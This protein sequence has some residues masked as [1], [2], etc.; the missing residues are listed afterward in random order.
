[1][2]FSDVVC[3]FCGCLCDDLQVTVE[4]G[5]ITS[6]AKACVLGKDHIM[7]AQQQVGKPKLRGMEVPLAEALDA[8]AAILHKSLHPM[9][10][11]LS[12]TTCEAQAKA[13]ELAELLG[14]SIDSSASIR[15]ASS[16]LVRQTSGLSS[17]SL[18]EVKNRA[19]LIIYWGCNTAE[20][21]LRHASRYAPMP[22]GMFIPRGRRDRKVIVVDVRRTQTAEMAD[23][24][25]PV[26]PGHDFECLQVMRALLHGDM[27]EQEIIGGVELET[28]KKLLQEMKACRYGI[29]FF[30]T[31]LTMSSGKHNNVAAAAE[32]VRHLNNYT[33][34]AIM[35]IRGHRGHGNVAGAEQTLSRL[36]GFPFAV[37]FSR[38]YPRYG[39][40]EF[41]A[42]ELLERE[43]VDSALVIASDPLAHLPC[44]AAKWLRHIPL[45]VLD[46]HENHTSR[47]AEVF[48]PVAPCGVAAE[49]T[50]YRMDN[51]PLRLQKLI[52]ALH[53]TDEA[54]LVLLKER[55]RCLK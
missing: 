54:L 47:Q 4:E 28:W 8:A 50:A 23:I 21:H 34:F 6:I 32:L 5:K 9:I 49:G 33:K 29:I 20:T 46:V 17:C 53:Q 27:P 10:Y 31:G 3:V 41:T 55:I 39:P 36:T 24:F 52:P 26:Q 43:E 12:G 22:Q 13:V 25:I 40:G 18:G 35:P 48:I 51:I 30:D 1:M 37:N 14:A 7:A 38:G 45:I 19:D 2:H 16:G 15:H 11:G 42:V 44:A